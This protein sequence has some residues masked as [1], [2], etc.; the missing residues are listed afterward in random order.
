[1]PQ[2]SSNAGTEPE[3][4]TVLLNCRG[5]SDES[6][7]VYIPCRIPNV[8]RENSP[9]IQSSDGRIQSCM[10]HRYHQESDNRPDYFSDLLLY[11]I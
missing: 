4:I 3:G 6:V 9:E 2:D 5:F 11:Q 1:M 8:R 10:D 7:R